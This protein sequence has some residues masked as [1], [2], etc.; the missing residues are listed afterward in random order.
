MDISEKRFQNE[1]RDILDRNY[2]ID[3]L[4][5]GSSGNDMKWYVSLKIAEMIKDYHIRNHNK[6]GNI[7]LSFINEDLI[8]NT[9]KMEK[10]DIHILRIHKMEVKGLFA[11]FDS[12]RQKQKN[13]IYV[14]HKEI[15]ELKSL[16]MFNIE[17]ISTK[18]NELKCE[19]KTKDGK[20]KL[21]LSYPIKE[22][23]DKYEK[24]RIKAFE[25]VMKR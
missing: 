23:M 10:Y 15:P 9:N 11:Y 3:C 8:E 7:L 4:V 25:K 22:L 1:L 14:H 5:I 18:G 24:D 17:V 19:V 2:G 16:V 12:K 20:I 6:E 21:F 13:F